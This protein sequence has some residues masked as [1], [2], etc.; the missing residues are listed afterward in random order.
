MIRHAWA[1]D[2]SDSSLKAG[3]W[4]G[5]RPSTSMERRLVGAGRKDISCTFAFR[6]CKRVLR[7]VVTQDGVRQPFFSTKRKFDRAVQSMI[8]G[9]RMNIEEPYSMAVFS[10]AVA[11]APDAYDDLDRIRGKS[12]CETCACILKDAGPL[13]PSSRQHSF[14]AGEIAQSKFA[15]EAA[16]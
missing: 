6:Q 1:V 12:R 10:I 16:R 13:D 3:E 8:A 15:K 4:A 7:L 5:V 9:G 14:I 2:T 11:A